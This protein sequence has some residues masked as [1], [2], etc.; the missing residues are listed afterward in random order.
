MGRT[1]TWAV[2]DL[3]KW[4]D[5]VSMQFKKQAGESS[6]ASSVGSTSFIIFNAS[7]M[8]IHPAKFIPFSRKLFNFY[9]QIESKSAFKPTLL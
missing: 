4:L 9:G 3:E 2:M 5:V 1:R 6:K 8:L 7:Q